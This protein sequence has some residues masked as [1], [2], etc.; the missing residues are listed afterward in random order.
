MSDPGG[1]SLSVFVSHAFGNFRVP[2]FL[3]V[4]SKV[5]EN[6]GSGYRVLNDQSLRPFVMAPHPIILTASAA[7]AE[8][9]YPRR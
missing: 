2:L 7:R 1:N 4:R 9:A 5:N 8:R 6:K 3:T